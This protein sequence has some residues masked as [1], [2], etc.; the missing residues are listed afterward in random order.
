MDEAI[1]VLKDVYMSSLSSKN[2]DYFLQRFK[3]DT[4]KVK[5]GVNEFIIA[6]IDII[7][8]EDMKKDKMWFK[9]N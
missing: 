8:G 5:S 4:I 6:S 2:R 1:S 9:K 7:D 3:K